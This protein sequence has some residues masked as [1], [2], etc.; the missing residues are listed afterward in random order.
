MRRGGPS[1]P[2]EWHVPDLPGHRMTPAPRHG[3]YDPLGPVTL[4]RWAL[5]DDPA[6]GVVIGARQNAHGALI[7][8]A[9]GGCARWPSSTVSAVRGGSPTK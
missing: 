5:A 6:T 9:G 3:A 2:I 7:L 4:A 1:P 8:A